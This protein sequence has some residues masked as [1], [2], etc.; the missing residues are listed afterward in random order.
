MSLFLYKIISTITIIVSNTNKREITI[1]MTS[2]GITLFSL[3][4]SL[5]YCPVNPLL[6]RHT[7]SL[8][9]S[10]ETHGGSHVGI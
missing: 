6:Q 5:Q 8:T 3:K 1:I 2:Y 7:L 10:P 9:H 4:Y